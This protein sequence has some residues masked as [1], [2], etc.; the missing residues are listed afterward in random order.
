MQNGDMT[1]A[2]LV[3]DFARNQVGALAD[4]VLAIEPGADG[5]DAESDAG[6]SQQHHGG[7]LHLS[8]SGVSALSNNLHWSTCQHSM[9]DNTMRQSCDALVRWRRLAGSAASCMAAARR[10][11]STVCQ[12]FP[13]C[14]RNPRPHGRVERR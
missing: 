7:G 13:P 12:H 2:V 8:D 3:Q 6:G 11:A 1:G 10:G 9:T 4:S 14:A 5:D